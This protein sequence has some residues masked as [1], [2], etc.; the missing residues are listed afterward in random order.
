MTRAFLLSNL[1]TAPD[2]KSQLRFQ[3]PLDII[4][5]SLDEIGSFPYE[6]SE[7]QWHGQT[8]FVKG[9]KSRQ[10]HQLCY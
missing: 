3:V 1:S 9:T 7:T 8:L 2:D 4:S 6:P 10:V 5:E